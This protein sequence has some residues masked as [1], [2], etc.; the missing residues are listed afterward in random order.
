MYCFRGK[1]QWELPPPLILMVYIYIYDQ[2]KCFLFQASPPP[3]STTAVL[4]AY[5]LPSFSF[6]L[7]SSMSILKPWTRASRSSY[8]YRREIR[9]GRGSK[10][11][12]SGEWFNERGGRGSKGVYIVWCD[13]S[14]ERMWSAA[15]ISSEGS[16][17]TVRGGRGGEK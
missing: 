15:N 12:V 17:T 13:I 14:K 10:G 16:I 8:E 3:S 2:Y 7:R 1:H 6:A 9:A 4:R 5:T 11:N